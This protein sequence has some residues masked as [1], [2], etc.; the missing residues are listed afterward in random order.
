V[1]C[2]GLVEFAIARAGLN[3]AATIPVDSRWVLDPEAL[4]V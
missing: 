2:G 3:A 1:V 4:L